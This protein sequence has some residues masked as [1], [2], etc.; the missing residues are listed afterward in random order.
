MF[1][2]DFTVTGFCLME[3]TGESFRLISIG[4]LLGDMPGLWE[5]LFPGNT[6]TELE[7]TAGSNKR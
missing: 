3:G 7:R 1:E 6:D 4:E 2:A 5:G